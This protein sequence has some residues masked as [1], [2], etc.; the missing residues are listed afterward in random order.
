MFACLFEN[1][2]SNPT[3]SVTQDNELI[4]GCA[5]IVYS[6]CC[7]VSRAIIYIGVKSELQPNSN[8]VFAMIEQNISFKSSAVEETLMK[9]SRFNF[10]T[11]KKDICGKFLVPLGYTS[12]FPHEMFVCCAA[13][14]MSQS[15]N[16]QRIILNENQYKIT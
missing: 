3:C 13:V 10:S 9:P 14:A 4:Q 6:C 12:F 1:S 8:E 11:F 5:D 2:E 16:I 7:Y 15:I